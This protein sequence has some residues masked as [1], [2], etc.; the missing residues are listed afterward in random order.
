M[1][2]NQIEELVPFLA[3]VG[4]SLLAAA[5]CI[6][7]KHEAFKRLEDEAA[8]VKQ[9]IAQARKHLLARALTSYVAPEI[10]TADVLC[11]RSK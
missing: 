7:G 2:T 8:Q 10:E 3:E 11:T 5:K 6:D 4:G 1:T 9:E